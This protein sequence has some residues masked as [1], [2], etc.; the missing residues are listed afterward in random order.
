MSDEP[1]GRNMKK[2]LG[3]VGVVVAIIS[4]T[5]FALRPK[6]KDKGSEG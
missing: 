4:I 2:G 6:R 1:S 3:L 5:W